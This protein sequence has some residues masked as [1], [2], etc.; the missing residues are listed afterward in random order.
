[1][2]KNP[3]AI[4]HGSTAMSHAMLNKEGVIVIDFA[5]TLKIAVKM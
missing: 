5:S 3:P 2:Q 4:A 1:M